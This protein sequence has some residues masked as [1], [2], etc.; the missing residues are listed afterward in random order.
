MIALAGAGHVAGAVPATATPPI[1]AP[2]S[3]LHVANVHPDRI[4]GC[5]IREPNN[6][7]LHREPLARHGARWKG[8]QTRLFQYEHPVR[9]HPGGEIK[10]GGIESCTCTVLN[11]SEMPSVKQDPA[12]AF[13]PRRTLAIYVSVNDA[14]EEFGTSCAGCE[15]PVPAH[16]KPADMVSKG[17]A[18]CAD[19]AEIHH[20]GRA[21]TATTLF[22]FPSQGKSA[23][24]GTLQNAPDTAIT[25]AAAAP[26][27]VVH[28]AGSSNSAIAGTLQNPPVTIPSSAVAVIYSS[29]LAGSLQNPS[30]AVVT[31]V[32]V[33]SAAGVSSP[34]QA[35][36]PPAQ[37]VVT[38]GSSPSQVSVS[39]VQG[40]AVSNSV[41]VPAPAGGSAAAAAAVVVSHICITTLVPSA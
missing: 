17:L 12:L 20:V 6:P 30:P 3:R 14:R 31:S 1:T 35:S 40:A 34:A 2:F 33:V 21:A 32:P 37:G 11:M 9:E 24:P 16:D 13:Q 8:C 10:L 5:L 25:T 29:A 41:A 7:V 27:P 19:D 18:H 36:V 15:S 22:T 38:G 39:N 23:Q 28:A 4:A 26:A